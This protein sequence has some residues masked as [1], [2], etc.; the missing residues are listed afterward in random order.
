MISYTKDTILSDEEKRIMREEV[1]LANHRTL[2]YYAN[3]WLP[4]SLVSIAAQTITGADLTRYLVSIALCAFFIILSI[5]LRVRKPVRMDRATEMI[6]Y[7]Q[8]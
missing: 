1:N 5:M 8:I 4:L 6:Y 7:V 2:A 3:V